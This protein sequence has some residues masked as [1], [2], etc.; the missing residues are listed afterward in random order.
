MKTLSA[1]V[2]LLVVS[3][4]SIGFARTQA[5]K[6]ATIQ[7]D[8]KA[9]IVLQTHLSSKLSEVG[10]HITAVLY[11]SVYAE[12]KLVI[13]RGTEFHGRVTAV[14]PAK[15]AQKSGQMTVLF[16]RVSMPWGEEPVSILITSVDD[17]RSDR[18]LKANSEG[19]VNGGHN[20]AKTVG[21]VETGG[22]IGGVA[23]YGTTLGGAP[24]GAGAGLVGAGL[25]TGLVMTKGGEVN[26]PPGTTFRIKF[27][28]PMSLPVI[29]DP[30][31]GP[32]PIQP[33]QGPDH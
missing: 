33:D 13:P 31:A 17:W 28:K 11:E 20:G 12:D 26:L 18:K 21:N 7:P 15:R 8:T 4:A 6:Q 1:T 9:Q 16:D 25:V 22:V 2:T 30:S 10:D 5:A 3:F 14:T 24:A 29:A 32:K 27:V 23:A 19:D